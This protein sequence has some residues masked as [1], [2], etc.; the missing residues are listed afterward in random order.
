M[1]V[2]DQRPKPLSTVG[3]AH[4]RKPVNC[5]VGSCD[6]TPGHD[7]IHR[8]RCGKPVD[9]PPN[10]CKWH[11]APTILHLDRI[12]TDTAGH[13]RFTPEQLDDLRTVLDNFGR[14]RITS[15]MTAAAERLADALF[16]ATEPAEEERCDFYAETEQ[17]GDLQCK[18][19]D[20]HTGHHHIDPAPAEPS[21]E[22]TKAEA[23]VSHCWDMEAYAAGSN[24][25]FE[26]AMRQL[27]EPCE[28]QPIEAVIARVRE[29]R[30]GNCNNP[31]SEGSGNCVSDAGRPHI[32]DEADLR[33]ALD[34]SG[35]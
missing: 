16:T 1:D 15:D 13:L 26:E 28:E 10:G 20:G 34:G 19:R 33:A 22:E 4:L 18:R 32:Y 3:H 30:C 2:D 12:K 31:L 5:G 6:K 7:G 8:C 14:H 23:A 25:G 24:A 9:E 11:Q 27:A 17:H 21:E 29:I 35:G